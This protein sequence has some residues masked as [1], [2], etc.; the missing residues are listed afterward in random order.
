MSMLV[1]LGLIIRVSDINLSLLKLESMQ[2]KGIKDHF[3]FIGVDK[4]GS[5]WANN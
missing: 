4:K 2:T 5:T 1:F 3:R